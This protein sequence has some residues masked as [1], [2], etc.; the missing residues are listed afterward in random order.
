MITLKKILV[1]TDFSEHSNKALLYGAELAAKFGAELHV[2]HA[3]EMTPLAY[4][5]GAYFPPETEAE[6][7]AAASSQLDSLH[8]PMAND[9]T[10]VRK[11]LHGHPFVETIR[12]SK[13]NNIGLIVIGTH[14]RG[15]IAHMLLGSVAEKV[16]R[17]AP[18]P[19]LT[20]RDK[21]HDFVMP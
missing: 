17:K 7:T 3:I 13:E 21:E 12:Y 16:V 5:E 1:P 15:A 4:G 14:G 20:V 10:V 6:L 11:I 2:M 18:C 8:I 9:V 19:V